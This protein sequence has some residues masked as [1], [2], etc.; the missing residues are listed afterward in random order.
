ML[1]NTWNLT[2]RGRPMLVIKSPTKLELLGYEGKLKE[3]RSCLTFT[4]TT[5]LYAIERLKK[6][7][8][9]LSKNEEEYYRQLDELK[10]S[11]KVCLLEEDGDRLY[12]CSGMAELLATTFNDKIVSEVV[13]PKPQLTPWYNPPKFQ[14]RPYQKE[15]VKILLE[16]RHGG[17]SLPTGSGKSACI[18]HLVKELGLKT[19]ITAPS[20]SIAKQ[21]IKLF[22]HHL[23][24]KYVGLFGN[25]KKKLGKLVT[26]GIAQSLTKIEPGTEE[27]EDLSKVQVICCDE[28]HTTP[29]ETLKKVCLGLA[30]EAQYRFFFSATQ[31]RNDGGDLL[32]KA[33][34]GPIVLAL[35]TEDMVN[36]GYLAKP[37]FLIVPAKSTS[38]YNSSDALRMI[39][40]HIYSNAELHHKF[41]ELAN[42]AVSVLGHQVLI[43]IDHVE[44]FKYLLPHLKHQVEFA[45]GPLNKNNEKFLDKK[46]HDS[47]PTKLVE[48]FNRGEIPILV[49][50]SCVGMG[51]DIL[52]VKSIFNLMAGKSE[53][54]FKQLVGRGMRKVDG[55]SSFNFVDYDIKN[56]PMI[57]YQTVARVKMYKSSIYD[58][59]QFLNGV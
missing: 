57:H 25:G 8:W 50:T 23:G 13:Y 31:I 44:Q 59:V 6:Q 56:V 9:L 43:A 17:V 58:N 2:K 51:T 12:T 34:I 1:S 24:S 16:A 19:I 32:L 40:K 10:K 20:V 7:V 41:A 35:S 21:L 48:S 53:V 47:D 18:L 11:Q 22:E 26:I 36:S 39:N 5:I 37:K 55:K 38:A 42:Q 54:K 45:H 15:A 49:A 33:I 46:Y 30:K 27:W 4:D 52:P 29:T 14:L 28:S 3:L